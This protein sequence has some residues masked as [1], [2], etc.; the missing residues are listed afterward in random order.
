MLR[1]C[2]QRAVPEAWLRSRNRVTVGVLAGTVFSARQ[3]A[4]D[5]T[6]LLGKHQARNG[7]LEGGR[8]SLLESAQGATPTSVATSCFQRQRN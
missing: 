2:N 6:R 5:P 4:Q 8:S 7:W 3:L 1:E